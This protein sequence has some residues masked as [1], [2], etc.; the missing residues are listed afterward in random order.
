MTVV[1]CWTVYER[2]KVRIPQL[3]KKCPKMVWQVWP[4]D[5][6]NHGSIVMPIAHYSMIRAS[7]SVTVA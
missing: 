3:L 6:M 1:A 4:R 5:K 7:E 2:E